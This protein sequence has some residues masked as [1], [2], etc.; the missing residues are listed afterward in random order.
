MHNF[1]ILNFHAIRKRRELGRLR[2]GSERLDLAQLIQHGCCSWRLVHRSRDHR[3]RAAV[4]RGLVGDA[5]CPGTSGM[6]EPLTGG[7]APRTPAVAHG[8]WSPCCTSCSISPGRSAWAAASS[9]AMLPS[10]PRTSGEGH[11]QSCATTPG[12]RD[13]PAEFGRYDYTQKAEYWALAW[14][15]VLMVVTGVVLWFPGTGGEAYCPPG[16]VT[17]SQTVH[18]Y[19]AWLATSWRSWSGIIFF[20]VFHPDEYPMSWTWINGRMTRRHAE[21]HHPRGYSDDPRDDET[22][23]P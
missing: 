14:G 12:C 10:M 5:C 2:H 21:K 9:S 23:R 4:S 22:S 1:V 7:C 15:T 18:Y 16:S 20:V 17:A 19:E 3:F 13:K 8:R 6:D 11:R